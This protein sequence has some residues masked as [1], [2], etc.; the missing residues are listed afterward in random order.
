MKSN[1]ILCGYSNDAETEK[2]INF[3]E[4]KDISVKI[5]I[6]SDNSGF[7]S[8]PHL[9]TFCHSEFYGLDIEDAGEEFH[10]GALEYLVSHY[11]VILRAMSRWDESITNL[12]D[13]LLIIDSLF[14]KFCNLIRKNDIK[15]VVYGTGSPHHFY[16]LILSYAAKYSGID[17]LFPITNW[18]TNRVRYAVN[19]YN[20]T[21]PVKGLGTDN[22]KMKAYLD[23]LKATKEVLSFDS[24]RIYQDKTT[25]N[26][27]LFFFKILFPKILGRIK[28]IYKKERDLFINEDGSVFLRI[29]TYLR[30]TIYSQYF[31]YIFK[32]K[33]RKNLSKNVPVNA[34][35]FYAQNQ[36]E[37]TS[38]PDGGMYPDLRYWYYVFKK[39]NKIVY[40][41]EHK[42]NFIHHQ[43]K[44]IIDTYHHR[45]LAYLNFFIKRNVK[46][47]SENYETAKVLDN[48]NNI[49]T[50]TGSVILESVV[51]GSAA[52]YCGI[53]F[54]GDLAGTETIFKDGDVVLKKSNPIS[55]SALLEYF[56]EQ[57]KYSFP[58]YSG[59]STNIKEKIDFTA[60]GTFLS[61][62][63]HWSINRQ[64]K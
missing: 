20:F 27:F 28:F 16:N 62:V 29:V 33:Y 14:N 60:Y 58:N 5:L 56:T 46:L 10:F 4:S 36:P 13:K 34:I 9:V 40:Y 1:I 47:L 6:A 39:L 31:K 11:P 21:V 45:S 61:E 8:K 19:D 22:N 51:K 42:A 53:P 59:F 15:V 54:H 64:N 55:H 52:Y 7:I 24:K 49:F 35:V 12:D 44:S 37:A 32:K 3:L 41:K 63:I 25:S 17:N 26:Y 38:H 43:D 57:D 23:N 50:F 30:R 48:N 2:L 18:I